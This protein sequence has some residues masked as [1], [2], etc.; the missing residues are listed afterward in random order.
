MKHFSSKHKTQ[1]SN[2]D[3]K[4]VRLIQNFCKSTNLLI[5]YEIIL[6]WKTNIITGYVKEF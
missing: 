5:G 1:K 3:S 4:R 6:T 2:F